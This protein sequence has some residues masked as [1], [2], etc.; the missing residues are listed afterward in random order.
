MR[1][2]GVAFLHLMAIP[3]F[4]SIDIQMQPEVGLTEQSYH[5]RGFEGGIICPKN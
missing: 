1:S 2:M 5:I 4:I 3:Y